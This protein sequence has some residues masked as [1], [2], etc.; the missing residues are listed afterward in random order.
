MTELTWSRPIRRWG[1]RIL[2][3]RER[4]DCICFGFSIFP[5]FVFLREIFFCLEKGFCCF[6]FILDFIFQNVP[7]NIPKSTYS[8]G[9][10]LMA[11]G[12]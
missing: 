5:G 8:V 3:E 1:G 11:I 2:T 12:N 7:N 10:L 4:G 6:G 9:R